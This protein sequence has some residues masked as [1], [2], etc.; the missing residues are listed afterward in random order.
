LVACVYELARPQ[1]ATA[2]EV[3]N[4]AIVYPVTVQ[5]LQYARRRSEGEPGVADV[6][7]VREVLTVPPR[8]IRVSRRYLSLL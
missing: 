3:D 6:V 4:E 7:D 2:A 8:R 1:T 5:D